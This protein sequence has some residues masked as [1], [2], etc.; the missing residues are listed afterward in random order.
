MIELLP[1]INVSL[2]VIA[3]FLLIAG[4]VF[5]KR[6]KENAHRKVMLATYGVNMLFLACYLT[7][8]FNVGS[9]SFPKDP[10]VAAPI[11]RTF[12]L[13]LLFSHVVLA[14][15]VPFLAVASI[16][17]G[18]SGR[19]AA[20]RRVS[21]WTWPIWLYVSITGVVV[22]L[23]LYQIYVPRNLGGTS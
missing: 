20:H 1:H 17:L 2:N 6:G 5:I 12:Y 9:K 8:H 16:W 3:T 7:Y 21:V 4:F 13:I 14:A 19:R 11:V 10:N 22:Y 15:I 23:M 18:L